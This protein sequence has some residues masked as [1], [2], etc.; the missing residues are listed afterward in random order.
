[1]QHK[2]KSSSISITHYFL[3]FSLSTQKELVFKNCFE[4]KGTKNIPAMITVCT[5]KSKD[6]IFQIYWQFQLFAFMSFL[7]DFYE[8]IHF[9]NER[10]SLGKVFITCLVH[11]LIEHLKVWKS[12]AKLLKMYIAQ[13]PFS[14]K[15][16]QMIKNVHAV[17]CLSHFYQKPLVTKTKKKLKFND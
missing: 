4:N 2:L 10:L 5:S 7:F 8:S 16:P 11:Y 1:M 12:F 13:W 3:F 15:L 14:V 17:S 6:N 9:W